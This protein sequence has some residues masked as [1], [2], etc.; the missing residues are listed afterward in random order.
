VLPNSLAGLRRAGSGLNC[1][2]G[3]AGRR[4]TA[5]TDLLR[6][7]PLPI[8]VPLWAAVYRAPLITACPVD[9]SLWLEGPTGS[10]K[11]TLAGLFLAHFGDFDWTHLLGAWSSTAN[12]L[13][14]RAFTLKD[15]LFVID[16][17]A[18]SGHDTRELEAWPAR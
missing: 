14:R 3:R 10:M 8:T 17:Y 15:A 2:P 18:P 7:A 11:S 12:Q 16:D 9:F 4:G 5:T 6:V 13:E 1:P